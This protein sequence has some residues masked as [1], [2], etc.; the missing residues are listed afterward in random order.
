MILNKL[1][2]SD[3]IMEHQN[4]IKQIKVRPNTLSTVAL[5][6]KRETKRRVQAEQA[7]ANKKVFGKKNQM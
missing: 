3:E 4:V 2:Q 1:Y 5:R 6:V 7:K